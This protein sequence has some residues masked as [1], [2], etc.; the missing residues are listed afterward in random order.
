MALLS[1]F[2]FIFVGMGILAFAWVDDRTHRT[3]TPTLVP[4]LVGIGAITATLCAWEVL[5]AKERAYIRHMIQT[6][7]EE[8][9]D[10]YSIVIID[11][12][13]EIYVR[14]H[15]STLNDQEWWHETNLDLHGVVWRVQV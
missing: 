8:F 15:A 14:H 5:D 13:E 1:R 11:G 10:D 4:I 9:G 3:G 6:E 2:G 7:E 12:E